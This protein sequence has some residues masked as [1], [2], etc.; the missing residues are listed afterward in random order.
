M[1]AEGIVSSMKK[2]EVQLLENTILLSAIIY[3]DPMKKVLLNEEQN[4][5]S[6]EAL[7]EL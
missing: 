6:K 5:K 1:I 7:Y 3:V 4:A 2:R